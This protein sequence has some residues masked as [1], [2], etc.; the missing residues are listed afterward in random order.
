[1]PKDEAGILSEIKKDFILKKLKEGK[2]SDDRLLDQYREISIQA[3]YIPR[4]A[5]S[6]FVK[7]GKTKVLAGVKIEAGEP[8]PDTPNQGV[9]TTN[10]ELL[11]MAFPTFEAGPPNEMSIEIARVVDRGI[12]ESK[13]IDLEGLVIEPGKKVWIV[14]VDI[15]VLDY[16]G[17]LIDACTLSVISALRTAVVPGSSIE[18][19]KDF[20]LPV[21][22][23]PI[24]VTMVKIGSDLICDPD[25]EEEQMGT[26]RLTVTTTEDGHIRAMQK[27]EIGSLTLD[28][29]K[30][31]IRLSVDLGK[32]IRE[33]YFQ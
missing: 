7:L 10:V 30:K 27:G 11:P 1:M 31:A 3:N 8:F 5:G 20:P 14:F 9:L 2:R 18:G 32:R 28:E 24:S 29:I 6:A 26:T 15:D 33:K 22:N 17:N 23:T 19:G 25:L 13:M 21:R 4:S 16:D 12:R